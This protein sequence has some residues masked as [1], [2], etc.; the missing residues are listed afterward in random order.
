MAIWLW[1]RIDK[2]S[3]EEYAANQAWVCIM[4]ICIA[5]GLI[6]SSLAGIRSLSELHG[7]ATELGQPEK[8][9]RHRD[10]PKS[11]YGFISASRHNLDQAHLDLWE[12]LPP[13][14]A[15][16]PAEVCTIANL[17]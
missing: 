7:S 10:E 5:S 11:C 8:A 16:W 17:W 9:D 3:N 6:S 4:S 12:V 2:P 14:T 1:H 15:A 13:Y